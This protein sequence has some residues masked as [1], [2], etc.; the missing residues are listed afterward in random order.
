[1]SATG[2]NGCGDGRF[3]P[4]LGAICRG[5]FDFT[6]LFEDSILNLLPASCLL[7]LA[8]VRI[9]Q[10]ARRRNFIRRSRT[11]H[12]KLLSAG[13]L[14]VTYTVSLGFAATHQNAL[15][16]VALPAAVLDL[17]AG[18][19]LAALVHFEHF[20]SVR[21]SL[22]TCVF[23]SLTAL[24]DV[25]RLRTAWIQLPNTGWTASLTAS[26][27]AKLIL[28]ALESRSKESL[29]LER[30]QALSKEST[31]GP[32]NRA[33]FLWLNRLLRTGWSAILRPDSL[34]L[35][36]E[37]LHVDQIYGTLHTSWVLG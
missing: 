32:F 36:D 28:L 23:L 29:L 13:I 35:I 26:L 16:R 2:I 1:M 31:S 24:L 27:I 33:L 10:L 15:T 37:R 34:P 21:P 11:W 14:V 17:A 5:G 22:L 3:G 25:A 7:L 4:G 20:K 30:Y 9:W 6:L 19:A 18:I 8:P 12:W